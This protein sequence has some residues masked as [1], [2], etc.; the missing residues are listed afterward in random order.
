M[1]KISTLILAFALC[2]TAGAS[3]VKWTLAGKSFTTSDASSERAANYYVAVFLYDNF[4]DV[5]SALTSLGTSADTAVATLNDLT[6]S[7]GTTKATGAS[8]GSF[9]S[10]LPSVTPVSLFMVAFDATGISSAA[11]Y[12]VSGKVDSDAFTLPDNPTND[13]AFTAASFS[14][15]SWTPI[16]AVPEP[17]TAALALAGLALL[18]KRRKA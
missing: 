4:A 2:A 3:T 1:K 9:T 15:N 16:A 6:K 14:G 11:N 13:G 17:S 10:D 5:S 7:F 18:L 8:S 12:L